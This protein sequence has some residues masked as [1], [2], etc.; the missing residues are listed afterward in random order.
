MTDRNRWTVEDLLAWTEGT[1]PP[2]R[3]RTVADALAR[4]PEAAASLA[5]LT[6]G[7]AAARKALERAATPPPP[8]LTRAADA[9]AAGLAERRRRTTDRRRRATGL[10]APRLDASGGRR[11]RALAAAAVV[12]IAVLGAFAGGRW[13]APDGADA[14]LRLAAA[15]TDRPMSLAE[16]DAL[17]RALEQAAPGETV[18]WRSDDGT[19]RGRI[20]AGETVDPGLETRCRRFDRV[21]T[22]SA[23]SA[24]T[25]RGLA[26]RDRAG[27]WSI[28]ILPAPPDGA[29]P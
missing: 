28:L 8:G 18:A 17:W 24:G 3:A 19:G 9:L 27:G 29:D 6:A 4:D 26:C 20:T 25:E 10:T 11:R 15:P 12:L 5:R 2:D 21:A 13:S 1:L 22:A 14:T 16:A 23:G 7:E